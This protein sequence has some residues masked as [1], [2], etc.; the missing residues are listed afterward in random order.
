MALRHPG[1]DVQITNDGLTGMALARQHCHGVI[2]LAI[3]RWQ[4][5]GERMLHTLLRQGACP[6]VLMVTMRDNDRDKIRN[7]DGGADGY[8]TKPFNKDPNSHR[9]RIGPFGGCSRLGRGVTSCS[10]GDIPNCLPRDEV[11]VK[12]RSTVAVRLRVPFAGTTR[13][14]PSGKND[15]SSD[16][17]SVIRRGRSSCGVENTAAFAPNYVGSA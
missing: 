1:R 3:H 16:C 10:V 5:D 7:L 9:F 4:Q 14:N 2:L 11:T 6:P 17:L 13:I 12:T 8:L 15:P